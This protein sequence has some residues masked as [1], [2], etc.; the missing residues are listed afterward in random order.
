MRKPWSNKWMTWKKWTHPG[1]SRVSLLIPKPALLPHTCCESQGKSFF[2]QTGILCFLCARILVCRITWVGD[3]SWCLLWRRRGYPPAHLKG[4]GRGPERVTDH[5]FA[6]KVPQ[7]KKHFSPG[8]IRIVDPL[9]LITSPIFQNLDEA[10]NQSTYA[11]GVG[12]S[13]LYFID[14]EKKKFPRGNTL[15]FFPFVCIHVFF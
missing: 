4:L 1:S 7:P 10:R 9:R 5:L 3:V 6:V 13:C 8:Q 2:Q 14:L 11:P 15:V 12:G